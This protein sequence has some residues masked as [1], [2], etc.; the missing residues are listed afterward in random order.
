MAQK[1]T[2]IDVG[3]GYDDGFGPLV[4]GMVHKRP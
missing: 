1:Q 4:V 3:V 2:R